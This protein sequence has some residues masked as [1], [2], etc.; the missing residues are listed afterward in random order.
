MARWLGQSISKNGG[1]CGVFL[2][3]SGKYLPKVVQGRTTGEPVTGSWA[4]K[5]HWSAWGAKASPSVQIALKSY[6]S[7]N[8]WKSYWLRKKGGRW[9]V[10]VRTL[11]PGQWAREHHNWTM[12]QWKRVAWSDESRFLLHHTWMRRLPGEEVARGCTMGRMQARGGSVVLWAIL[13]WDTLDPHQIC[14]HIF[15]N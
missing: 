15:M 1:S 2:L 9:P 12:E 7:R 6:C 10:S 4:P 14:R 3:Y 13:C 5:A 8:C 11:T